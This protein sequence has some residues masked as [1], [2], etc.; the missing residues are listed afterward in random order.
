MSN[1]DVRKLLISKESL[2]F[3]GGALDNKWVTVDKTQTD[4]YHEVFPKIDTV[5]LIK[6]IPAIDAA[7]NYTVQHYKRCFKFDGVKRTDYFELV[8]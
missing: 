2:L 3:V 7:I 1:E 8:T 4:A 6:N 5:P